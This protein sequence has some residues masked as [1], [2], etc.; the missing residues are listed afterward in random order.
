MRDLQSGIHSRCRTDLKK[1]RPDL[2]LVLQ[3][4]GAVPEPRAMSHPPLSL[5]QAAKVCEVRLS[6]LSRAVVERHTEKRKLGRVLAAGV[7]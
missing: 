4:V 3:L 5:K 6:A 7:I 2:A 1:S